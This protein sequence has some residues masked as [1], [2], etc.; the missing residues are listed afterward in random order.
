MG[1]SSSISVMSP[2]IRGARAAWDSYFS[3]RHNFS[4]IYLF[5]EVR[6]GAPCVVELFLQGLGF[7]CLVSGSAIFP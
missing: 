4:I 3:P 2:L 6:V 7:S 5:L 1:L